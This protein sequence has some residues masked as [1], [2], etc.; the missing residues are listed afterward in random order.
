ML[1][2]QYMRRNGELEDRVIPVYM[3]RFS[4]NAKGF[5]ILAI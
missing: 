4:G 1:W 2:T 5:V 3:E